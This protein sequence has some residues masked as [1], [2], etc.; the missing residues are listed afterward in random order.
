MKQLLSYIIKL[1]NLLWLI[2]NC[3]LLLKKT[4]YLGINFIMESV[5]YHVYKKNNLNMD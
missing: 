4:L 1:H 5:P 2:Q 3:S